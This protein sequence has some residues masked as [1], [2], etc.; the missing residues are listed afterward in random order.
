MAADAAC[1]DD[2]ATNY[3]QDSATD[4]YLLI[5][6][7]SLAG[8]WPGALPSQLLAAQS[9]SLLGVGEDTQVKISASAQAAGYSFAATPASLSGVGPDGDKDEIPDAKDNCPL[10]PNADQA[11]LD[12]DALGD[13]LGDACDDDDDNDGVPD[14]RDAFPR[15]P[16]EW[17]DTDG[18]G[19]GNNAD[20][21][22]DNDGVDDTSDNCPLIANPDQADQDL[23]RIGDRGDPTPCEACLPSPGGWRA[24]LGR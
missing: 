1:R 22:D 13:A 2:S 16:A 17:A 8:N 15:D 9:T 6:W 20:P 18:D 7:A 21:D 24:I 11:N 23:D 3:D 4:C 10:V 14:T 19:I 5:A 12:G